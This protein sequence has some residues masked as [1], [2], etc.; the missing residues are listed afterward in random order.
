[1]NSHGLQ[2]NIALHLTEAEKKQTNKKPQTSKT[3][4]HTKKPKSHKNNAW[5]NLQVGIK[6]KYKEIK[7]NV[8][9]SLE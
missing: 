7:K 5:P 8:L 3:K 4:P 1:M 2:S 9:I 6:W